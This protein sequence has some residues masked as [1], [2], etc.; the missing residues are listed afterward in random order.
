MIK[1]F[2]KGLELDIL[3][4]EI[5]KERRLHE[6]HGDADVEKKKETESKKER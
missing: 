5:K 3:S 4:E 2:A 6:S 1:S